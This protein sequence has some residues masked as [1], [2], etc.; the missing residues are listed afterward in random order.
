MKALVRETYGS[1]DILELRDI[2]K[3][4]PKDGEVL[5]KIHAASVNYAD[6]ALLAGKPF[7]VRLDEGVQKP[8]HTILGADIAGQIEAV[9]KNVEQ[10]KVGDD[11]FG[12]LS[13]SGFGGFAEFVCADETKLVLKPQNISFEEAAAVPMAA[14][15]A[16]K[17]L[18]DKGQIQ[19][20]QKV[21]INGAS[22][23]VG[24]F[25]VQ[26][27][28]A[29]GADVTAVCSTSKVDMVRALGADHVID[30]KQEDFTQNGARYDLI[31][32]SNGYRSILDY[33]RLLT[34]NG[35][36]VCSGGSLKQ[37]FQ[38]MLLGALV[39][40]GGKQKM[41]NVLSMP[42]QEALTFMKELIEAGKIKPVVDRCYPLR[43]GAEA[44]R[45]VTGGHAK[46]KAIVT[47]TEPHHK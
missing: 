18:K 15:T 7:L 23:G 3:P 34:P 37:I 32:A 21:L 25:A 10:F 2:E 30:Y 17:G 22:G 5:I 28:K 26:I 4:T 14:L 47:M 29:F 45:Y 31:L 8:K 20:G 19:A 12:D 44:M 9:G 11:V 41:G 13:S 40:I 42:N 1:P 24:T 46:G 33:K 36:Y 35:I 16:L 27:A 43:D 6:T 38:A 39:T